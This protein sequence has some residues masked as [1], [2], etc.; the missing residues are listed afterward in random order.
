[1]RSKFRGVEA[2]RDNSFSASI[3]TNGRGIKYLGRY[4]TAEAAAKAV[5]EARINQAGSVAKV[6]HKLNFPN[7]YTKRY[8]SEKADRATA[9]AKR[10]AAEQAAFEEHT[11]PTE[12][13]NEVFQRYQSGEAIELLSRRYHVSASKI[14]HLIQRLEAQRLQSLGLT[15][16]PLT[17]PNAPPEHDDGAGLDSQNSKLSNRKGKCP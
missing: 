15:V 14:I 13:E 1:M 10:V 4:P 6:W 12:L 9:V 16:T 5:D 3:K 7:E 11:I 8:E 17:A 2:K